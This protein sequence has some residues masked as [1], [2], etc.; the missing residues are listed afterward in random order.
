MY[1]VDAGSA[2]EGDAV[3]SRAGG[4]FVK[5]VFIDWSATQSSCWHKGSQVV[6]FV[7]MISVRRDS[8]KEPQI[9]LISRKYHHVGGGLNKK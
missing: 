4:T 8:K 5:R 7:F 1:S 3:T 9:P 2:E 6:I